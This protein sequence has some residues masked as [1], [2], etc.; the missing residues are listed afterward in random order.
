MLPNAINNIRV[1][2]GWVRLSIGACV[3]GDGLVDLD[4]N[5]GNVKQ[6]RNIKGKY[7]GLREKAAE[8]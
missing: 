6:N 3:M 1:L 5:S 4:G 8:C 7:S 2:W